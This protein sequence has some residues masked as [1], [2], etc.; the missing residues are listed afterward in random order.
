MKNYINLQRKSAE[1]ILTM[2][3]IINGKMYD[4]ETA[5][6]IGQASNNLSSSD[7]RYY[8]EKL[9]RKKTGEFFLYG[10]GGPLTEYRKAC[11]DM[12][13][14]G[15]KIIPISLDEA[16][17]WVENNLWAELYIELFGEVDE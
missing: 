13:S 2:R 11:G 1:R 6:E 16:K 8:E 5:K 4:T 7:F 17:I 14:G 15:S 12:W 10:H 9:F 3:K